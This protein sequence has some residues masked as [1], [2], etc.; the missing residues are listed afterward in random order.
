MHIH[1]R[2]LLSLLAHDLSHRHVT[3][4]LSRFVLW[5]ASFPLSLHAVVS[6]VSSV[7]HSQQFLQSCF[8]RDLLPFIMQTPLGYTSYLYP[9]TLSCLP[10]VLLPLAAHAGHV[11]YMCVFV[12]VE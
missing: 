6:R 7:R 3:L 5:H 2:H 11:K 12:C 9:C 1:T 10:V 4:A 8:L